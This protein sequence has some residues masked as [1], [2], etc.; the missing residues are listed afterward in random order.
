LRHH[1]TK[2]RRPNFAWH[3]DRVELIDRL[4]NA[5]VNLEQELRK[6]GPQSQGGPGAIP[7]PAL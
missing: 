2:R 3:V 4:S 7:L 5:H 1:R 6:E